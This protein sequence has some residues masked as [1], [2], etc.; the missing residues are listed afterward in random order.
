MS[1]RDLADPQLPQN[2]VSKAIS[3]KP[4]TG[5]PTSLLALNDHARNRIRITYAGCNRTN[6]GHIRLIVHYDC[7][8][9]CSGFSHDAPYISHWISPQRLAN[10]ALATTQPLTSNFVSANDT[11]LLHNPGPTIFM[12]VQGHK[13]IF[14]NPRYS[15]VTYFILS[16]ICNFSQLVLSI[17]STHPLFVLSIFVTL[18]IFRRLIKRLSSSHPLLSIHLLRYLLIL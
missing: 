6:V 13:G 3:P 11:R 18:S 2:N 4:V 10:V 17:L 7:N 14:S 5:D 9:A 16:N 8:S 12:W 1:P 15:W